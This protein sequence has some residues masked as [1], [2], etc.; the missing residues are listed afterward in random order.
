MKQQNSSDQSLV[1]YTL[2]TAPLR[3]VYFSVAASQSSLT[4]SPYISHS[5]PL[6]DQSCRAV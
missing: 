1:D 5:A 4:C 3:V 2:R 6:T